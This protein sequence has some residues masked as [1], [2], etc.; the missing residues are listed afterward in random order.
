MKVLYKTI[1]ADTQVY[2]GKC[3]LVGV[4]YQKT[5]CAGD[6]AMIVYDEAS[7]DKTAAQ[8]VCTLVITPENQS[9]RIMF[10]KDREPELVG[11]YVDWDTDGVGTVYYHL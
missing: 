6:R 3:F 4:E 8:K 1:T 9:D 5:A 11:I 10:P 7:A 2:V